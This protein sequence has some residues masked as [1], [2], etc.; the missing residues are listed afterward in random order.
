MA[1][2]AHK[3]LILD[4]DETTG[5]YYILF[6]LYDLFALSHFGH[7]LDSRKTLEILV[8]SCEEF[9]V[10]RPGLRAFLGQ[11][12][13]MKQKGTIEKVCLY[14]NQLDVRQ[15]YH[16]PHWKTRDGKVWSVPLMIQ[17]MFNILVG[18]S[19]F[20]DR[21]FTRPVGDVNQIEK[22]PVKDLARVYKDIYPKDKVDL[23]KTLFV[24]DLHQRKYIIDSTK[25]GTDRYSRCAI[26][27]YS[28]QLPKNTFQIIMERILNAHGMELHWHNSI[29]RDS[30][31][32]GWLHMNSNIRTRNT[33]LAI[34]KRIRDRIE[35]FFTKE[36]ILRIKKEKGSKTR[37]SGGLKERDDRGLKEMGFKQ[38]GFK[39]SKKVQ[40]K[41]SKERT[42]KKMDI[43]N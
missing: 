29:L 21:L 30:V 25:S 22:Y 10:F 36:S 23:S 7:R 14:T 24:D 12:L 40:K 39:K 3:V 28:R 9:G 43:T 15:V 2:E 1:T 18:D 6:S 8:R 34:L 5:S 20:I 41:E 32:S 11:V 33:G 38:T 19:E 35:R 4:N 37:R 27:P 26:P 42:R 16:H 17:E 31:E 13:D